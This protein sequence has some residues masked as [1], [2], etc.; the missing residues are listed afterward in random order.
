MAE[1]L[2][3]AQGES[4]LATPFSITD[5]IDADSTMRRPFANYPHDWRA[6]QIC[7]RLLLDRVR[8]NRRLPSSKTLRA[9]SDIE[10]DAFATQLR[11]EARS[12]FD[13]AAAQHAFAAV[14][15]AD[16]DEFWSWVAG[17]AALAPFVMAGR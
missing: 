12:W 10:R 17:H 9:L 4:V 16:S 3:A 11:G 6:M 5:F 14:P 15:P 13:R 7:C 2:R 1:A 8:E